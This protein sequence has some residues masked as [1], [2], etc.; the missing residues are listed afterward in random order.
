MVVLEDFPGAENR[1]KRQALALSDAG[2]AVRIIACRGSSIEDSWRGIPIQRTWTRR[3]KSGG[4]LRR[5]FEYVA[6][7][8]ECVFRIAAEVMLH[9]PAVIQVAGPPDWLIFSAQSGRLRRA[10]VILDIHDP[11]PELY[12]AKGGRFGLRSLFGITERLSCAVS[13]LVL[14]P[15]G[16]VERLV[17]GRNPRARV[18]L[19]PNC[20]DLSV[21]PIRQPDASD[22]TRIVYHGT[23]A[24]R[25]GILESLQA[26]KIAREVRPSLRM[27]IYGDGDGL[28]E[29]KRYAMESGL[30]DS[31][32][33][34]GQVAA[35]T[36]SDRLRG[37]A[38]GL[39][40]YLDS[41]FMRVAYSTKAFEYAALGVPMVISALPSLHEQFSDAA[42]MF[43]PPGD[44]AA[45]ADAIVRS[46]IDVE[47]SLT[48]ARAAQDELKR[49]DWDTWKTRY[50]GLV[51][52]V[53]MG[54]QEVVG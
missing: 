10:R 6:F 51:Q 1:V 53:A 20:V 46:T 15:T 21:F 49:F 13:D 50:V 48:R 25:F 54:A 34:Y 8:L 39:V 38:V 41:P 11:M 28:A 35:D 22:G 18:R 23:V 45:W 37:T 16:P 5:V 44:V 47:D 43:V 26:L 27:D 40:P 30:G 31:V 32:T 36:L 19:V 29:C 7:P 14:T 42:A 52:A 2:Y 12:A 4:M 33:F 17:A 24:R 9:E 3:R